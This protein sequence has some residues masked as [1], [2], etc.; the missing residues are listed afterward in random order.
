MVSR[1]IV[2]CSLLAM[3]FCLPEAAFSAPKKLSVGLRV[4]QTKTV[5]KKYE[6]DQKSK[7]SRQRRSNYNTSEETGMTA[8][9]SGRL[10]CVTPLKE[11]TETVKVEAYF[12]SRDLG[13]GSPT[14]SS[15]SEVKTCTFGGDNPRSY[16]FEFSSPEYKVTKTKQSRGSWRNRS[17]RNKSSGER[18]VGVVVRAVNSSGEVLKV[19]ALPSNSNWVRKAKKSGPFSLEP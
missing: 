12:I 14:V 15:S 17:V 16:E 3:A 19:Q 18:H 2:V 5:N 6:T 7:D 11:G 9:F 8:H 10:Y 4:R 13:G 1:K